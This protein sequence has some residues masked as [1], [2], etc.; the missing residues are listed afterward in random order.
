MSSFALIAGKLVGEPVTR[1]TRTGGKVTFFRLRVANGATLE[2]WDVATFSDTAREEL[3]GLSEGA[4]LS[5]VG[6]FRVEPWEKGERRGFNYKLTADRVLALKP[7]RKEPKPT[8]VKP[9]RK[10]QAA[11]DPAPAQARGGCDFNDSVPF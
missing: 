4:P 7:K 3:D 2:F 8:A 5:A 10:S 11:A 9:G 1:D 6:E